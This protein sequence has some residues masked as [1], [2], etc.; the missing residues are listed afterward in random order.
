[1]AKK[2][3]FIGLVTLDFAYL[4]TDY[5]SQNQKVVANDYTATAG[6]PA[7]NAAVTF[8]YLGNQSNLLGVIG[9]HPITQLIKAD[10]GEFHINLI[11]LDPTRPESP[12]VSSIIIT[13]STADRAVI[14]INATKS[15]SRQNINSDILK[16]IDII[17][18]DG[19]QMAAS[20]EIAQIAKSN[21]I[22]IVVDAGSWKAGF[23]EILPL[24][25]YTICS[26][27]FYP[28]NCHNSKEV[29][30]YLSA[31]GIPH[32][33]ITCGEK[34]IQYLSGGISGIIEVPQ[35]NPVDTLGAGD[36]FHGAFCHYILQA[37]F[38]EALAAAAKVA[39]HSCQF[40]GTRR[41]IENRPIAK[42]TL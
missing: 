8:S 15:Q 5:P 30:T 27:N 34:P 20:K 33:A 29:F 28:P 41:W 2:G 26:G 7:T 37:N 39:S 18:I 11:D 23:E 13:Q 3:L 14:S 31:I 21:N 6:G 10:L 19:H 25:D 4:V 17:L 42:I 16:A 1:M 36:I 38:I 12:P 9:C 24:V 32:I 22:P 40:F 35:I